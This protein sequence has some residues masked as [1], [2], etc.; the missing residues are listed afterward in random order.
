MAKNVVTS[1]NLYITLRFYRNPYTSRDS[2][3]YT[4]LFLA[5]HIDIIHKL[6]IFMSTIINGSPIKLNSPQ[7]IQKMQDELAKVDVDKSGSLSKDEIS[8]IAP[9]DATQDKI[10][11][12]FARL[13]IDANGEIS[14]KEQEAIWEQMTERMSS[15][16]N[17]LSFKDGQEINAPLSRLQNTLQ[18]ATAAGDNLSTNNNNLDEKAL[19]SSLK[20]FTQKYPRVDLQA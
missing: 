7:T 2:F 5:V 18:Q 11:K 6:R 15:L 9:K 20:D 1:Q 12:M 8:A 16:S 17:G 3:T 13:D 10:D 4:G 19:S 14:T